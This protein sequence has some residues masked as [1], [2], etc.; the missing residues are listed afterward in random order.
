MINAS[1][2]ELIKGNCILVGGKTFTLTYQKEDFV[3]NDSHN[4]E[5]H[6]KNI[7]AQLLHLSLLDSR[8]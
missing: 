4:F 8:P 5:M 2:Y 6:L 3:S 7:E 1:R